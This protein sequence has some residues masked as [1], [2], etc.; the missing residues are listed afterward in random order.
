VRGSAREETAVRGA[1]GRSPRRER[2]QRRQRGHGHG[3]RLAIALLLAQLILS[4]SFQGR[5]WAEDFAVPAGV[6]AQLIAK[7]VSY[8]RGFQD[9]AAGRVAIAIVVKSS[10]VDSSRAASKIVQALKA[11]ASIGGLPHDEVLVPWTNAHDLTQLCVKM[12]FAVVYLTPGL[13][14][15][16]EVIA[17]QLAGRNVLTVTGSLSYVN[18]GAVLG[19]ELVSGRTKLVVNLT[20]AKKQNV[21]FR[22]EVLTLMKIAG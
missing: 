12:K 8:D 17:N 16:V 14:G 9:R 2:G 1:V 18:K 10:E 7:L 4:R 21:Q 6:Q 19:F 13:S 20:Q 11:L 5:A 15:D 3:Y 22:A